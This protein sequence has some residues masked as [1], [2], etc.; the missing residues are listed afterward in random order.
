M[1]A[2]KSFKPRYCPA[3][4]GVTDCAL[5]TDT[6]LAGI[7]GNFNLRNKSITTLKEIDFSDLSSIRTLRLE[8]NSLQALPAD[9]FSDL[10]SIRTLRLERNSLQTL[11]DRLFSG[12]SALN[13]I[14]LSYN[15]LSTLPDSV[16]YDL[17][18]LTVLDV[19]NNP[20]APF[21]LTLMLERTDNTD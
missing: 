20:G 5:V 8:R 13:R 21:T 11:P 14:D 17:S 16:F 9:L 15:M 6:H 18:G 1:V 3:I 19:S 2:R 12:L 7:T 4:T 10:S